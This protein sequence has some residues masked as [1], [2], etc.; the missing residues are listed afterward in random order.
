MRAQC[1][2]RELLESKKTLFESPRRLRD[3]TRLA[4]LILRAPILRT[5][6]IA[7]TMPRAICSQAFGRGD[8]S[9]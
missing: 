7:F 3:V 8:E 9:K 1:G 6:P 2:T 5:A 4:H